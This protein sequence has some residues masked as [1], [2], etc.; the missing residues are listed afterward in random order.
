MRPTSRALTLLGSLLPPI[1]GCQDA[2]G[3]GSAAALEVEATASRSQVVPG[4]PLVFRIVIENTA[5]HPV[6]IPGG[7]AA[8]LEVRNA[9]G[10]QIAFG[11]FGI[12]P[13]IAYPPRAL[14]PGDTAIDHASWAGEANLSGEAATAGSYSI[15]AAVPV[16]A[17]RAP[18]YA[19][20]GPVEVEL[21][22]R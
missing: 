11:M 22:A 3:P 19:Y 8:W 13:L 17:A 9:D 18:T 14:A 20:S 7:G 5:A 1:L 21:I 15:R 12:M 10:V 2:T 4:E 6:Q 16:L